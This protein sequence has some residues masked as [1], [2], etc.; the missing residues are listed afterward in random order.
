MN[1]G[2]HETDNKAQQQIHS[3]LKYIKMLNYKD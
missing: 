1:F 3:I 2:Y